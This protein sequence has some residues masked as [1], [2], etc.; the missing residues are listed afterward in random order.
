ME[1]IPKTKF[2]YEDLASLL[3]NEPWVKSSDVKQQYFPSDHDD[4][5]T[6]DLFGSTETYVSVRPKSGRLCRVQ[7]SGNGLSVRGADKNTKQKLTV[8]FDNLGYKSTP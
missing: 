6:G 5:F 2:S 4:T 1:F 8:F 7:F 3:R